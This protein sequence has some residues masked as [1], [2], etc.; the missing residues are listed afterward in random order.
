MKIIIGLGNPGEKFKNTR[1][2]FGFMAVDA[3][4]E[5]NNFPDFALSKKYSSFISEG[6]LA[7]EKILLAKP[8]TFMNESGKATKKIISNTEQQPEDI[9]VIHDDI[10]LA[11]GT[12]KISKNRGSAGHKGVESIITNLGKENFIR[13]R[14]GI[15]PGS[16]KPKN[17]EKFVIGNFKKEEDELKDKAVEIVARALTLLINEGAEKAMNEFNK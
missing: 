10:D 14:M 17:P 11:L 1:H 9:I 15:L 8:Q 7:G 16:M 2:N 12:I 3:F 6:I 4:A 5:K 13:I